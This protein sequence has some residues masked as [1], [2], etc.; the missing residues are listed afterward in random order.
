MV[1]DLD[2]PPPAECIHECIDEG[3]GLGQANSDGHLGIVAVGRVV[4]LDVELMED[5]HRG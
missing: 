1:F 3:I 2:L 4:Y 5:V